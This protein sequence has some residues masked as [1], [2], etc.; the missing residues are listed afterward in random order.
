[1]IDQEKASPPPPAKINQ[2]ELN[3]ILEELESNPQDC[4]FEKMFA[5]NSC[6]LR[7]VVVGVEENKVE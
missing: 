4:G 3:K 7:V 2:E 6:P 5:H 1:M